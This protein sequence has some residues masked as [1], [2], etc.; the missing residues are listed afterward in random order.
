LTVLKAFDLREAVPSRVFG[1][2]RRVKDD[3]RQGVVAVEILGLAAEGVGF[4]DGVAIIVGA[5][6]LDRGVR[7]RS[8][9]LP[10]TMRRKNRELI[11]SSRILGRNSITE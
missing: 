2:E 1:V 11:P 7:A 9:E 4:G 8:R 5:R 3:M 10:I 6:L